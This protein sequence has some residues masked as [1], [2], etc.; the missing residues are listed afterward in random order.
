MLARLLRWLLLAQVLTGAL[1]GGLIGYATDLASPTALMLT[2]GLGL[3]VPLLTS[4]AT[5]ANS[6]LKSRP[7]G[8]GGAWWRAGAGELAAAL[9]VFVLRQPWT[10]AP[11]RLQPGLGQQP[12][13]PVL[14][15][16]GYICNHRVW[17]QM[18][19]ALRARGHS[20]LAIN[21]EPLFC[22]I[23]RY[24]PLVEQGVNQLCAQSGAQQVALVGHSM[25]GL[26]LRAWLRTHGSSRA[27]RV[28]TLGTPHAGTRIAP[29]APSA[30]GQQ[31]VWHSRWLQDLAASESP[32]TRALLRIAL[33]PQDNIVYPQRE[34][35][36]PGA[37]VTVFDGLGHLQLCL[38]PAVI[39][40]VL[41][42][43]AEL[44][45]LTTTP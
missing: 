18:A 45:E 9:R 25:G 1:L 38:A 10:L 42:E 13:I 16:H 7:A 43:L 11:P 8:S 33:T 28:I 31:M 5:V 30:N 12:G 4:A 17:D 20:V 21:L 26:A 37:P 44:A 39:A 41:A 40:W 23:D 35:V 3:L 34:Q 29:H 27:A 24:A 14:L 6:L 36:L 2:L 22:S 32:A 15:V 19:A